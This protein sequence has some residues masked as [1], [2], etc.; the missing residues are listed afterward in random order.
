MLSYF[1]AHPSI[2]WAYESVGG[3]TEIEMEMEVESHQKFREITDDI[4][5][6]FKSAIRTYNYYLWSAEHKIVFFPPP[7]F[8]KEG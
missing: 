3:G 5:S 8:F 4:R 7:E 2:V 6:K 1:G